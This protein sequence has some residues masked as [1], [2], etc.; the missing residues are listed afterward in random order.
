MSNKSLEK[1]FK[2]LS[3]I[4]IG[5]AL[6]FLWN[7]NYE[8]V[9]VLSAL[10][11]ASYFLSYRYQVK[12]RLDTLETEQIENGFDEEIDMN[13]NILPENKSLFDIEETDF[14]K[15]KEKVLKDQQ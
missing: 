13:N 1:L 15:I 11:S 8:G 14:D 4:L 3:A 7:G 5:V 10:S 6:F 2:I 9:F 12:E